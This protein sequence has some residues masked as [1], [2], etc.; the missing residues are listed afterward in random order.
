MRRRARVCLA[1]VGSLLAAS[2]TSA[3]DGQPYPRDLTNTFVPVEFPWYY[4]DWYLPV[5]GNASDGS[6]WST[7]VAPPWW[8]S[9]YFR[10]RIRAVGAPYSIDVTQG[11]YGRSLEL[12]SSGAT[13]RQFAS[14]VQGSEFI[15]LR[16]GRWIMEQGSGFNRVLRGS[17]VRVGCE[18]VFDKPGGL[19]GVFGG[20]PVDAVVTETGTLRVRAPQG[21]FSNDVSFSVGYAPLKNYGLIE[22]SGLS[23]TQPVSVQA[24]GGV[25]NYGE[26]RMVRGEV[27]SE[28]RLLVPRGNEGLITVDGVAGLLWVGGNSQNLATMVNTGDIVVTDNASLRIGGLNARFEHR[29]GLIDGRGPVVF[30]RVPLLVRGGGT[31]GDVYVLRSTLDLDGG[32][33]PAS[34]LMAGAGCE[35]KGKVGPGQRV[36]HADYPDQSPANVMWTSGLENDGEIDLGDRTQ[37]SLTAT[38]SIVNRG[39]LDAG[40]GLVDAP[41]VNEG[42]IVLGNGA[43]LGRNT[44]DHVLGGIIEIEAGARATILSS[45]TT[46]SGDIVVRPTGPT[47]NPFN[48]YALTVAGTPHM[49]G[50]RVIVEPTP[51]FTPHWGFVFNLIS[52]AS[53]LG[54]F[55]DIVLPDLPDPEW[56]WRIEEFVHNFRGLRVKVQHIAN[57]DDDFYI[58]F[59]DVNA[60]VSALGQ[61]TGQEDIDNNGIVDEA[62]VA[63]VLSH[64]GKDAFPLP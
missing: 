50:L 19:I 41:I 11:F 22:I 52:V 6:L 18:L 8:P 5:S 10:M 61:T 24:D 37:F 21:A 36:E 33:T 47:M 20:P 15:D 35:L 4:N 27:D 45:D 28:R 9:S 64:F 58:D 14:E 42:T 63:I 13:V 16:H 44:V 34:F 7:G 46:L 51:G 48:S 39:L 17:V 40:R 1:G 59:E 57:M 31:T 60:V 54:S 3:Y 55:G 38:A 56:E 26:I 43:R 25:F 30:E 53:P 2:S 62:D 32:Q 29:G 12:L 23:T 49:D